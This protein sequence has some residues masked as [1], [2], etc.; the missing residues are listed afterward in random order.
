[1]LSLEV[2]SVHSIS[3]TTK[4]L[5]GGHEVPVQHAALIQH[6]ELRSVMGQLLAGNRKLPRNG[7]DQRHHARRV[8]DRP[9]K[10]KKEPR[11]G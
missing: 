10:N 11:L 5:E 2:G 3:N 4:R 6:A 1:M 8:G 9:T 7:P